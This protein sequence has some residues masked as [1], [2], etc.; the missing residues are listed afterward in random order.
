MT[1]ALKNQSTLWLVCFIHDGVA[2]IIHDHACFMRQV[3]LVRHV[4]FLMYETVAI[5]MAYKGSYL[6]SLWHEPRNIF[7]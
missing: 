7:I 4:A 5:M 2:S 1:H 6:H 3:F